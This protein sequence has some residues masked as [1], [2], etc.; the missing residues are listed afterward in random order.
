MSVV[1]FGS[2]TTATYVNRS[3][4]TFFEYA[5][6]AYSAVKAEIERE[7][8]VCGIASFPPSVQLLYLLVVERSNGVPEP[9]SEDQLLEMTASH[10]CDRS[11]DD[12][13]QA[14]LDLWEGY[15]SLL[16]H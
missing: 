1:L 5:S 7:I 15:A 11:E 9:K 4:L 16:R 2:N 14:A 6:I 13:L 10:F 12:L 3:A 8:D